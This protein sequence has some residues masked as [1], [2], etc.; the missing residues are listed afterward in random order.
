MAKINRNRFSKSN[1]QFMIL[2]PVAWQTERC[3]G[4]QHG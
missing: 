2:T 4:G 3:R 1:Q